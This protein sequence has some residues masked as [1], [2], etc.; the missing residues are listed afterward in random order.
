MKT[1]TTTST[2]QHPSSLM[3]NIFFSVWGE[4]K[5][6]WY[7]FLTLLVF[8]KNPWTRKKENN[9]TTATTTNIMQNKTKNQAPLASE[10]NGSSNLRAGKQNVGKKQEIF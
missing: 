5:N 1:A 9:I 10:G 7:S 2:Q 6:C 3:L 8:I 4:R